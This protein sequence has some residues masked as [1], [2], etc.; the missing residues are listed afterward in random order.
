MNRGAFTP[1]NTIGSREHLTFTKRSSSPERQH[2]SKQYI[3]S[4]TKALSLENQPRVQSTSNPITTQS[5]ISLG[6]LGDSSSLFSHK[7]PDFEF[8]SKAIPF[9]NTYSPIP[10]V[11]GTSEKVSSS[12]SPPQDGQRKIA[13][14]GTSPPSGR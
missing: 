10:F 13:C 8:T 7:T 5:D 11:F 1:H 4:P 3:R 6:E 12:I 9:E 2:E 14:E